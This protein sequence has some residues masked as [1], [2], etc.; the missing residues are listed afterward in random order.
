MIDCLFI[1]LAFTIGLVAWWV[2]LMMTGE[3][4]NCGNCANVT[5]YH[6][7]GIRDLMVVRD[8]EYC[9]DWRQKA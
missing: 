3:E 7:C 5:D 1:A 2:Y 8:W 4:E 6:H 9:C